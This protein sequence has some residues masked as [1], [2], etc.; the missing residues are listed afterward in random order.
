M[1]RRI[2]LFINGEFIDSQATETTPVLN[3]ATQQEL[4]R[5]PM[6]TRNEVDAAV[7]SAKHAFN[8]W[9]D[10][11]VPERAR[12]MLRYQHLLKQHRDEIAEI[13]AQETRASDTIARVGG[14]EFVMIFQGI[15]DDNLLMSIA[16][17]IIGALNVPIAFENQVCRISGSIGLT[18]STLY[19]APDIDAM[20]ADADTALYHSKRTGR[21][22]ATVFQIDLPAMSAG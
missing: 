18:K 16:G 13:L 7:A 15:D 3:P 6:A 12:V 9:R 2:P 11:A 19:P 20:H 5:V 14:D 8:T 10:V 17:R 1:T 21:G 22:R 4:A